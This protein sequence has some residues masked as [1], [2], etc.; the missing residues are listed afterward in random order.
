M[1]SLA[2]INNISAAFE[3]CTAHEI[4]PL[5]REFVMSFSRRNLGRKED[6]LT[7]IAGIAER[8]PGTAEDYLAGLWR[9]AMPFELLWRCDQSQTARLE[10]RKTF[11]PSWSWGSVHCGVGWPAVPKARTVERP[12]LGKGKSGSEKG[13]DYLVSGTYFERGVEGVEVVSAEVEAMGSRFGQVKKGVLEL[14]ARTVTVRVESRDHDWVEGDGDKTVWVIVG[15]DGAELPFYPDVVFGHDGFHEGAKDSEGDTYLFVEIASV[16]QDG[17]IWEAGLV[18]A[19][20]PSES[21]EYERVG[22]AGHSVCETRE[23]AEK[24]F[25]GLTPQPVRLV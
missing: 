11:R 24:W 19:K 5:W 3:V 9:K 17:K 14:V 21:G 23:G 20:T 12:E 4:V 16:K 13:L 7:A 10:G 6:R 18:V 2:L 1:D 22:M 8:L 25:A 15:M